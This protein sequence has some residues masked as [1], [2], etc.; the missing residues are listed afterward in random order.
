M[1]TGENLEEKKERLVSILKSYNSLA[2]AFSG[3]VD[4]SFLLALAHQVLGKKV[5]AITAV[6]PVHPAR[7]TEFAKSFAKKRNIKHKI[8]KSDEMDIAE[9][10]ANTRNRCYICKKNLFPRLLECAVK[11]GIKDLAHGANMDDLDDFRPGFMAASE[12]K[13]AAPLIDAGFSKQQIRELSK[14]MNLE[15][16]NKPAMACLAT[17]I[18][19]ETA[20]TI[21]S[22][23]M[24]EKAENALID[25]GFD[26]CRVRHHGNLARIEVLPKDFKKILNRENKEAVIKKI[27]EAGYLYV[28]MD[29]EGYI[30]GSMNR[31]LRFEI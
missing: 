14:N 13:I 25:L 27:K 21:E 5:I 6:S 10:T 1:I 31:D 28:A 7:E 18:P 29:L 9:F 8:I 11:S 19:Y 4:S 20:I 12:L 22:L 2:I 16:W 24:I 3:G 23:K 15:T 26:S 17:R 30:R